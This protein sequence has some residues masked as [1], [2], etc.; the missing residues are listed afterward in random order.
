MTIRASLCAIALL[1][2]SAAAPDAQFKRG[3]FGEAAEITLFPMEPPAV[4]LPAGTIEVSVRNA[5][6]A[7]ARIVE[8]LQDTLLRQLTGNDARLRAAD[9]NA[10]VV[11][12]ATL[13]EWTQNR[14]NSTKYVSEQRQIGTREVVDKNGKKKTEPVYEYG[15]N[16]PSV[17]IS[18]AAG[19][20]LEVK[21][22]D[23]GG[24]ADQTARH[25]IQ[26]EHLADQS[27]PS[28]D[29]V[30]DTLLDNVSLK[31]AAQVTPG[32]FPVR[33]LLA[34]SNEVDPLNSIAKERRWS[35]WLKELQTVRANRD[36]KKDAYRL[37]NLAVAHESLAYEASTPDDAM[38]PLT[39][40]G[41]LI[42]SAAQMNPDEKYIKESLDRIVRSQAAYQ[43]LSTMY[44][45]LTDAPRPQ[46]VVATPSTPTRSPGAAMTNKDVIDLIVAGL[47]D[48]NLIAAINDAK[49]VTFDLSPAGLKGLLAGKVSNRVINAMRARAKK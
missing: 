21:R 12:V 8:R 40:A 32:R 36:A 47:D 24:V 17:V 41:K 28:R 27:P 48:E 33:V 23:G 38:A 16:R 45:Q 2:V 18:A 30:E 20:R 46:P 11:V 49:T 42:A 5:S 22:R 37:H 14:R 44:A 3:M 6:S 13:T 43:R 25:T 10:D 9:K 26:E 7:S 1:F 19:V 29:S 15:R 39:E 35:E 31:A 4:L 34:R